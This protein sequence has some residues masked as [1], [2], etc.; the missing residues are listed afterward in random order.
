MRSSARNVSATE[1][2]A[3]GLL[4]TSVAIDLSDIPVE[5]LPLRAFISA[6]SLAE[7]SQGPHMTSDAVERV[8]RLELLHLI[9]SRFPIPLPFDARAARRYGSL[10]AT[11]VAAGRSPRPRKPDLMIAAT[12]AVNGLALFTRNGRDFEG[13]EEFVE[14]AT[15]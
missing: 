8:R 1:R 6:V 15:V 13:L 11:I 5:T 9:E 10:V 2:R 3:D 12:A 4:D 7:L 14:V